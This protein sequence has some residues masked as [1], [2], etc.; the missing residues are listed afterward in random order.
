MDSPRGRDR[1][2]EKERFPFT[3]WLLVSEYE[4]VYDDYDIYSYEWY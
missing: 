4:F 3:Y 2:S 1:Q